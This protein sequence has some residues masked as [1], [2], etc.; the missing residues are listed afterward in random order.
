VV[1]PAEKWAGEH[2]WYSDSGNVKHQE[3]ISTFSMGALIMAEKLELTMV[4]SSIFISS[5]FGRPLV[6]HPIG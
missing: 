1:V 6:L 5:S 3:G 2:A 4:L